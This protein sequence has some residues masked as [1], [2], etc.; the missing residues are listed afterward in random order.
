MEQ[1]DGRMYQAGIY[2]LAAGTI[3]WETGKVAAWLVGPGYQPGPRDEFTEN[4]LI[5]MLPHG[6]RALA[7]SHSPVGVIVEL[8]AESVT[9]T[10]VIGARWLV[11]DVLG[12]DGRRYLLGYYDIQTTRSGGNASELLVGMEGP[13]FSLTRQVLEQVEHPNPPPLPTVYSTEPIVAYRTIQVTLEL[14]KGY[15]SGAQALRYHTAQGGFEHMPG[16][17]S[18]AQC[19][20][21]CGNDVPG[22][23]CASPTGH[24]CGFYAYTTYEQAVARTSDSVRSVKSPTGTTL[25][26]F[27]VPARVLLYGKVIEHQRGWRAGILELDHVYLEEEKEE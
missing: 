13:L 12:E 8:Y 5:H 9:F 19:S 7:V 14:V 25:I 27:T 16:I 18:L 10:N 3:R 4:I 17:P 26:Q 20:H 21:G 15:P 11:I 24:G 1:V 6:Y 2:H 22:G 23:H